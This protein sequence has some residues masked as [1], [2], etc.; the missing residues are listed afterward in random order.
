MEKHSQLMIPYLEMV[1][2]EMGITITAAQMELFAR[3]DDFLIDYNT[4]VN[5]TG[6]TDPREVAV[7]HFGDSLTLF[8]WEF[9]P[10]GATVVDVGTGGGFPGIPLAIT[11]PDLQITLVDSLRKRTDFL[12]DL[13][14]LLD[15]SNVTVVWGRAE[16]VGQNHQYRGRFDVVIARAL[17]PLNVLVEL[18]LP[19]ANKGGCFL[20]M[21][22]PKAEAEIIGATNAIKAIGGMLKTTTMIKL[23]LLNEMRTLVHIAK[24]AQTPQIY[25]RRAGT[26]ERQPL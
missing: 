3:Y 5:L 16:E 25:P 11:R 19:L 12:N 7:K 22:G 14:Q 15:L 8:S 1:T 10:I 6:I 4:R 21:K 23:P 13:A 18:C 20:A 24:I 2:A 17:A 9:L 26:P